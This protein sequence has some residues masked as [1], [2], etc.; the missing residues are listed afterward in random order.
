[1]I[2][3]KHEIGEGYITSLADLRRRLT[4]ISHGAH[5]WTVEIV[6]KRLLSCKGELPFYALIGYTNPVLANMPNSVSFLF[7]IA[8]DPEDWRDEAGIFICLHPS[9]A[10]DVAYGLYFE[11]DSLK[12]DCLE[13]WTLF[14]SPLG[15][16][17][18]AEPAKQFSPTRP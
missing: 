4:A 14:W 16:S 6:Q 11:G 17:L 1:M 13:D 18:M 3:Y 8:F 7:P 10:I 12:R 2:L 5:Q 9:E 15:K